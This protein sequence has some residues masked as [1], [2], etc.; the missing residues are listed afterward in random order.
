MLLAMS[1]LAADTNPVLEKYASALEWPDNGQTAKLGF[2]EE[3]SFP[4]RRFP[5]RYS[6]EMFRAPDGGVA[7]CYQSPRELRLI[8]ESDV[9][10]LDE[11]DGKLRELRTEGDD[12][13]AISDLLRGDLE[14]LSR[15][16]RIEEIESGFRL[17]PKEGSSAEAIDYIDVTIA[18]GRVRAVKVKQRDQVVRDYQFGEVS[19]VEGVDAARPFARQ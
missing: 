18:D 8:I 17:S 19:W 1:S 15:D 3:R 5:K 16:W 11:G 14:A 13:R 10:Q 2:D 12:A 6:G 9:I 7:I 4:F